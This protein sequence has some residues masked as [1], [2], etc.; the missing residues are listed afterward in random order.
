MTNVAIVPKAPTAP[1]RAQ[2][3]TPSDT[4]NLPG[5]NSTL[6][7]G[8]AGNLTVIPAGQTDAVLFVA[9]PIGFFPV[10]VSRVKATGTAATNIVAVQ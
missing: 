10:L 5:G 3:V 9:V 1:I 7:I 8:G 6:Y 4:V 2:A